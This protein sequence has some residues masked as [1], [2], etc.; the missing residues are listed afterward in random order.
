MQSQTAFVGAE[1]RVELDSVAAIDLEVAVVIFP[2][3]TELDYSLRDRDDFEG[4]TVLGVL[5]EQ[6]AIFKGADELWSNSVSSSTPRRQ[7]ARFLRQ[8][9]SPYLGTPAGTQARKEG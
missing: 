3:D 7:Q 9:F 1:S 2:D 6:R 5:C 4:Y 8:I